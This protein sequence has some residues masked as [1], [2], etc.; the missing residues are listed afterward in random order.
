MHYLDDVPDATGALDG[1]VELL[2]EQAGGLGNGNL[3][4]PRHDIPFRQVYG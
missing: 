3:M 1:L 2:L 4:D